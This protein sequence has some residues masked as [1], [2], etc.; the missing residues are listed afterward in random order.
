MDPAST[1]WL[2]DLIGSECS[3]AA[4]VVDSVSSWFFGSATYKYRFVCSPWIRKISLRLLSKT[5]WIILRNLSLH[6]T[7]LPS[8]DG[9]RWILLRFSSY[10]MDGMGEGLLAVLCVSKCNTSRLLLFS[11]LLLCHKASCWPAATPDWLLALSGWAVFR[12]AGGCSPVFCGLFLTM[13]SATA[14][15]EVLTRGAAVIL[16]EKDYRNISGSHNWWWVICS[17]EKVLIFSKM[18][19]PMPELGGGCWETRTQMA[20]LSPLRLCSNSSLEKKPLGQVRTGSSLPMEIPQTLR[21]KHQKWT[22]VLR[23]AVSSVSFSQPYWRSQPW[24]AWRSPILQLQRKE[25]KWHTTKRGQVSLSEAVW[26]GLFSVGRGCLSLAAQGC[27]SPHPLT[28]LPGM[29]QPWLFA[30]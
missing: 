24:S 17:T 25:M 14:R 19:I 29:T 30:R 7:Y 9:W 8:L 22:W 3:L 6:C 28:S 23:V 11:A 12:E 21:R 16:G 20:C 13:G 4:L 10:G 27:L 26:F 2:Q 1:A 18:P 5:V 15:S